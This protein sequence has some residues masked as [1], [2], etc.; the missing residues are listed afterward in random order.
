MP[1]TIVGAAYIFR[2]KVRREQAESTGAP[3]AMV[4]VEKRQKRNKKIGKVSA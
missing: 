4:T 1:V 2:G 3:A